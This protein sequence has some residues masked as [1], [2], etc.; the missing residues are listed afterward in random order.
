MV[1]SPKI[2]YD[3][4]CISDVPY[5]LH[6]HHH[7]LLDLINLIVFGEELLI[8]PFSSPSYF[9]HVGALSAE[10]PCSAKID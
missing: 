5:M 7:I 8:A 6:T 3:F 9:L 4:V 1:L 10:N 2:F